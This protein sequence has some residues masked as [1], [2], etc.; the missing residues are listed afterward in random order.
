MHLCKALCTNTSELLPDAGGRPGSA[1]KLRNAAS[2]LHT[3]AS[4]LLGQACVEERGHA[5]SASA[6]EPAHPS[7]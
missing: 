4:G 3:A 2:L 5:W 6:Q 7:G 1:Q